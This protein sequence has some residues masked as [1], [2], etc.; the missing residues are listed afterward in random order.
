MAVDANELV[1]LYHG[2]NYPHPTLRADTCVTMAR[3]EAVEYARTSLVLDFK[4]D[5]NWRWFLVNR[6]WLLQVRVPPRHLIPLDGPRDEAFDGQHFRLAIRSSRHRGHG[7]RRLRECL[8]LS[9]ST[10][11]RLGRDG[12]YQGSEEPRHCRIA[13]WWP[14]RN[15]RRSHPSWSSGRRASIILVRL[16]EPR[17]RAGPSRRQI[18]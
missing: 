9:L 11:A 18:G 14:R 13:F 17:C 1:I 16:S 15:T 6:L 8:A 3:E 5:A 2:T 10:A 7:D 12:S 4:P